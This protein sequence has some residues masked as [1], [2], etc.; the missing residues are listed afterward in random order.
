MNHFA[1][2]Q[3]PTQYCKSTILQFK[4]K[5]IQQTSEYNKKGVD[6]QTYRTIKQSSSCQWGEGRR[7]WRY[8]LLCIV[9]LYASYKNT[10]YNIG[11]ITNIL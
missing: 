7:D 2:H 10:L 1:V 9:F 8:K 5:K 3:K 4:N 6:S 11:D